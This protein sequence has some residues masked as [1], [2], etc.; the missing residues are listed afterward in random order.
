MQRLHLTIA[1]LSIA[2]LAGCGDSGQPLAPTAAAAGAARAD[3]A[4][5]DTQVQD[6]P[7]NS[8]E[9]VPCANGGAG[10]VVQLSGTL[11][12]VDHVTATSNGFHIQHHE[13]PQGVTGTG[14]TT[15]DSY[16]ATGAVTFHANLAAGEAASLTRSFRVIGQGPASNFTVH[17]NDHLTVNANGEVT[18][19]RDDISI[20]C[21]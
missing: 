17:E 12:V 9:F 16:Q 2:A 6:V 10:E 14:L 3:A 11:H 1:M 21:K 20:E 18:V 7:F 19:D 15:G 5:T 4:F 8:L 13:N